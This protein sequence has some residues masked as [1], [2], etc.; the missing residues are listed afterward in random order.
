MPSL[1]ARF[2]F[3]F[4]LR[5]SIVSALALSIGTYLGCQ[6]PGQANRAIQP[7]TGSPPAKGLATGPG[8][9]PSAESLAEPTAAKGT[10][11]ALLY[12]SNLFAEYEH[13]GCPSHPLGGLS[14]RATLTDRARAEAHGVLSVDA[15][16]LLMPAHFHD[17]KLVAPAAS[18]IERRA[19]L[20]LSI[21]ARVG[22]QAFLPGE[23]DLGIGPAKLRRLLAEF[24][25]PTVASNLV[26]EQN[27]RLF[28]ADILLKIA[29]IPV[30]IFGVIEP[31]PDD[32]EPWRTWKLHTL[33]AEDV[34]RT[35]IASL[36]KRGARIIV[37]LVHVGS[38]ERARQ[39]LEAAPGIDWAVQGH[40]GMQY[41]TPDMV[42]GTR[43]LEAFS[44]GKLLG[45][46]DLHVVDD[47]SSLTD[48]GDRA[49]MLGIV[50]DHRRQLRDLEK[51]AEADKTDQLRAYY[52]MRRAGLQ[53]S[54]DKETALLA[55]IPSVIAGSWFENRIIPLDESIPDHPGVEPLVA[56]YNQENAR[57]AVAGLPV[58]VY[59]RAPEKAGQAASA[60]AADAT[61]ATASPTLEYAG[62]AACAT[63]HASETRQ[64]QLTKHAH[65][66]ASLTKVKRD[67]DPT[68]VGCHA[69]GYFWPG[70]TRQLSEAIGRFKDVG[71]ESCHGPSLGHITAT[72]KKG[73]TRRLVG[74]MICRSCHTPDQVN[75]E[76]D[77]RQFLQA[78]LGEGHGAPGGDKPPSRTRP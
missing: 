66:L 47:S 8:K 62:S 2:P 71:C 54:I 49:Q 41:E 51:R 29:G 46:M 4:V 52:Q 78:V 77:Y 9:I 73:T 35:E 67:H 19:R 44:L 34:A 14:R 65:A 36:R 50:E 7:S 32:A 6:S 22:I 3:L 38:A 74:E 39:L 56:A 69:T 23:S 20:L 53:T 63:C 26:D 1:V 57:R 64:H 59:F 42:G 48:R 70:G 33:P 61:K 13:C 76:F 60:R 68:C 72:D 55:R 17:T 21:Y 37:A 10:H 45:R 75:G 31:Q 27:A 24:K 40:T 16:D 43:R 5:A 11:L 18:E 15:G 12:S 30:G 58:G 28:D 25:I